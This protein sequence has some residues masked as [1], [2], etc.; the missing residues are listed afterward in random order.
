MQLL[1]GDQRRPMPDDVRLSDI[2]LRLVTPN[3]PIRATLMSTFRSFRHLTT[4]WNFFKLESFGQGVVMKST[5]MR[6]AFA[7][8][9]GLNFA[10]GSANATVYDLTNVITSFGDTVT[11]SLNVDSSGNIGQYSFTA[12]DKS[13]VVVSQFTSGPGSFQLSGPNLGGLAN[14]G[15]I[16]GNSNA[17]LDLFLHTSGFDPSTSL[18]IWADA[19]SFNLLFASQLFTPGIAGGGL[20]ISGQLTQEASATPLP[21]ALPLY[22]TGLGALAL[23]RWRRQRKATAA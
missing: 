22:A 9:I 17:V 11:G 20:F 14:F 13:H 6:T 10:I 5:L 21:A 23:L 4:K 15:F 8:V 18:P 7:A 12:Y 1:D 16:F 19:A 3:P 2:E